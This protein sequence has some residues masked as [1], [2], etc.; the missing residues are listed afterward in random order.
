M[1]PDPKANTSAHRVA[2]RIEAMAKSPVA[3]LIR[4]LEAVR[5]PSTLIAV[6]LEEMAAA[7]LRE[8]ARFRA[9][10]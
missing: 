4:S 1:K 5:A 10:T 3:D 2:A 7:A 6:A 8:A 9:P